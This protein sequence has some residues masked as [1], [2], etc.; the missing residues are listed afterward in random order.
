MCIHLATI[1]LHCQLKILL[2]WALQYRFPNGY[3]VWIFGDCFFWCFLKYFKL[4]KKLFNSC[5][6]ESKLKSS[7]HNIGHFAASGQTDCTIPFNSQYSLFLNVTWHTP[8]HPLFRQNAD[9]CCFQW[10]S[11][12]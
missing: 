7:L 3:S 8:E 9:I 6:R 4:E 10:I 11:K 5:I 12:A 1:Q 2:M